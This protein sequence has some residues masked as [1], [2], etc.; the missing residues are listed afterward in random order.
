MPEPAPSPDRPCGQYENCA[1]F[2]GWV[3]RLRPLKPNPAKVEAKPIEAVAHVMG[4]AT[5]QPVLQAGEPPAIMTGTGKRPIRGVPNQNIENN[6][7]QSKSWALEPLNVPRKHFDTS[8]K[9]TA[10]LHHHV[11]RN[12][13][14]GC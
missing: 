7:M 8:G 9:S 12:A 1:Q 11:W 13:G 6:P 2:V 3:E 5:A 14:C 10:L 4:F